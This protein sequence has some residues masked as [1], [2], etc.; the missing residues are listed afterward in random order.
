MDG[1]LNASIIQNRENLLKDPML[2]KKWRAEEI[3]EAYRGT[4]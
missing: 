4:L 3:K 2:T 1:V